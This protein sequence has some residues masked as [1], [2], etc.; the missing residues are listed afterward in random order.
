[1]KYFALIGFLLLFSAFCVADSG[2]AVFEDQYAK[3]I[4][5]PETDYNILG[6]IF[7]QT[8]YLTNKT[9]ADQN[10]FFAFVFNKPLIKGQI[11][12]LE[13]GQN[14]RPV[15]DWITKT[16]H[17]DY[18]FNYSLNVNPTWFNP[19]LLN[20][21]YSDSNGVHY[22]AKDFGFYSG[23]PQTKTAKYIQWDINKTEN[24]DENSF[25]NRSDF[26]NFYFSP[27]LNKAFYYLKIPYQFK[28]FETHVF[29]IK[30]LPD[31]SDYSFKWD[32]VAWTGD[33]WDCILFNSCSKTWF[34]DPFFNVDWQ[35]RKAINIWG[36]HSEVTESNTF[37]SLDVDTKDLYD[38]GYLQAD[39][40]DLRVVRADTQTA[41]P[42]FIPKEQDCNV[43]GTTRIYFDSQIAFAANADFNGSDTN[44]Y[45]LYYGNAGASNFDNNFMNVKGGTQLTLIDGNVSVDSEFG[46]YPK[47]RLVNNQGNYPPSDG[48]DWLSAETAADHY[49]KI[50][51]SSQINIAYYESFENTIYNLYKDDNVFYST[52]DISYSL[53]WRKDD[54]SS[55]Q[56]LTACFSVSGG[57]YGHLARP[58]KQQIQYVKHQIKGSS[59]AAGC[60]N[61]RSGIFGAFEFYIFKDLSVLPSVSLGAEEGQSIAPDVNLNYPNGAEIFYKTLSYDINFSVQD[62]DSNS[63][64]VDLNIFQDS[65]NFV[66]LNDINTDSATISCEDSDF[67]NSTVCIYSWTVPAGI[68]SGDWNMIVLVSD[69]L[70]DANDSTDNNFTITVQPVPTGV[71]ETDQRYLDQEDPRFIDSNRYIAPGDSRLEDSNR[72]FTQED[73]RQKSE[74]FNNKVLLTENQNIIIGVIALILIVAV[75]WFIWFRKKY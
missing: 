26:F 48:Y 36:N 31:P 4:V 21:F 34:I 74:V 71:N 27:Y 50:N 72:Y 15:F 11:F 18:D 68:V 30:Y 57:T 61:N 54:N 23:D 40:G 64:L 37:F 3:L 22:V 24:F 35:K 67:S 56:N 39:C 17:C 52:D 25:V 16:F 8:F 44:G 42:L 1:M 55:Y 43:L 5:T 46:G 19:H 73:T 2:Q 6:G 10:L 58:I 13:N 75:V 59:I 38:R 60:A 47:A 41:I 70:N 49:Y 32:M 28:P 62:G 65:N 14:S 33:S 20:C 51:L 69:G 45:W 29:K 12:N 7:E 53:S 63:L 9:A 66:L